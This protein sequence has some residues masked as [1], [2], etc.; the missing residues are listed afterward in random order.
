M[1]KQLP[2]FSHIKPLGI[3]LVII[4]LFFGYIVAVAVIKS[5]RPAE[6][7][8][9]TAKK[10]LPTL[11]ISLNGITLSDYQNGGKKTKYPGNK[12]DLT[13]D[14]KTTFYDDVEV[15][16]RGNSTWTFPKPPFQIK[17]S[18]K[19]SLFD[20]GNSKT[21][22]LLANYEDQSSLR[23]DLA[24]K[25]AEM[26]GEKNAFRGEFVKVFVDDGYLGLYYLT[27]KVEAK[28]DSV[29]LSNNLGVV[30]EIDNEHRDTEDC[31]ETAQH[32]CM[33]I[34]DAVAEEDSEEY[35]RGVE[36]FMTDWNKFEAAA[37]T[38]NYS[39]VSEIIDLESFAQYF[40]ISEF[41]VNP[42]AYSSSVYFYKDGLDDKIHAGPIWDYDYAFANPNWDYGADDSVYSPYETL[43]FRKF[44]KY[45]GEDPY[46]S[47]ADYY[48]LLEM[49]E[50]QSLVKRVFAEKM[51]GRSDELL[52]WLEDRADY[53]YDEV[54]ND[55]DR[56]G[57]EGASEDIDGL[58]DWVRRRYDYLEY[59]YGM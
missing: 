32:A 19:T 34:K 41:S 9:S 23:N 7:I 26:I 20:L 17:F 46:G 31:V 43:A 28:K 40:L 50:F 14:G 10:E 2:V 27:H 1:N 45:S 39:A 37:R 35:T 56:W 21:W 52:S 24:F 15:R 3:F 53:V 55:A 25:L 54:L 59:T 11:S 16:G 51:Q 8:V 12:I 47:I 57:R 30:M 18:E 48:L 58:I 29:E 49:P 33:T 6:P 22:V 42:D 38:R 44:P 36:A 13:V 4:F 5:M